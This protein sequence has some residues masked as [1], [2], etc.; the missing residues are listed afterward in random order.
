MRTVVVVVALSGLAGTGLVPR[1]AA[2]AVWQEKATLAGNPKEGM[3]KVLVFAPDGKSLVSVQG[4]SSAYEFQRARLLDATTLAERHVYKFEPY[5]AEFVG[6]TP[7]GKALILRGQGK[8]PANALQFKQ[9]ELFEL[10]S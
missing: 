5:T 10:A 6:F 8:N 3:V 4:S 1:A 2:Q 7:D 9:L